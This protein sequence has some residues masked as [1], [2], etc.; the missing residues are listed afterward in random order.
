M[1]LDTVAAVV[2]G[3]NEGE[4]LHRCFMSV[5]SRCDT[6]VYVDS[7]SSDGSTE[8][9]RAMGVDVIELDISIPFTAARARNAGFHRLMEM[10]V[11]AV[12]VQFVDGD[13]ELVAGWLECAVETMCEKPRLAAVCG[14]LHERHPEVS[15]YNRLC[16]LEWD[17]P[18]GP[19]AH[20]GGIALMR[21]DA[22]REVGGFDES[23]ICGEEPE[24]CLR[25]RRAGWTIERIACQMAFHDADMTR[26]GQWWKRA[27]RSGH[28]VAEAVW[29]H[30]GS[31]ERYKVRELCSI[32]C[33]SLM[34]PGLAIA[35]GCIH[36]LLGIVVLSLI[37]L[38]LLRI[39]YDQ[40]R[41][42]RSTYEARILGLFLI[43]AKFA[44]LQGVLGFWLRKICRRH[45]SLIEYKAVRD[46]SQ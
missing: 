17:H 43:I 24:L 32:L 19:A 5:C 1:K 39:V 16:D 18:P 36:P 11:E 34:I 15:I 42:G 8:L 20:C 33:W 30:G 45:P 29:L 2:I 38:Q 9:A 3:R 6:V 23:L 28:A 27:V 4:R 21:A 7:G 13:C 35:L 14:R 12:F 40:R 41:R 44:Q 31:S 26:F 22:L 37:P 46:P 10:G 25:F